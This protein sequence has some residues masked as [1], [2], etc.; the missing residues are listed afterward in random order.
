L[1]SKIAYSSCRV[2]IALISPVGQMD[3]SAWDGQ[4]KNDPVSKCKNI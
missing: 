3:K 2:I 4:R 1:G